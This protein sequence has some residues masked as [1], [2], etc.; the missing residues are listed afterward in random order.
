MTGK[1]LHRVAPVLYN[2]IVATP[3]FYVYIN[4]QNSAWKKIVVAVC[5]IISHNPWLFV[6]IIIIHF[7]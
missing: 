1:S 7:N 2:D 6:S 5:L 4:V 3:Q